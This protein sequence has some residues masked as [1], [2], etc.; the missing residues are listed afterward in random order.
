MFFNTSSTDLFGLTRFV[1]DQCSAL[2][3]T[4]VRL[5]S[6]VCVCVCARA[7]CAMC[8]CVSFG[9]EGVHNL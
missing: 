3:V 6:I 9:G 5:A 1:S 4:P 8:V 2:F 7:R